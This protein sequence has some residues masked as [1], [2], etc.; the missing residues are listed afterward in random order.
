MWLWWLL[1]CGLARA[2]EECLC[3]NAVGEACELCVPGT[4]RV[5]EACERCALGTYQPT[6]GEPCLLCQAGAYAS[7][8]GSTACQTCEA[9]K[10]AAGEGSARCETCPDGSSSALDATSCV[11]AVSPLFFASAIAIKLTKGRV[12]EQ[13][14]CCFA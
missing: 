5:A 10:F 9:G 1:L 7:H 12:S 14:L 6:Y 11:C 4:A 3:H 13:R 8:L 2:Q